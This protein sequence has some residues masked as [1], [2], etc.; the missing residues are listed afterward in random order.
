M[1]KYMIIASLCFL[2]IGSVILAMNTLEP[3]HCSLCEH[4]PTHAPCLVNLQTGEVGE[5]T[6][7]DPHPFKSDEL[8]DNQYGGYF[9][10]L[11][12]AGLT[13]YR[14][15]AR[16]E[17]HLSIPVGE[18]SYDDKFFC[19]ACRSLLKGCSNIGFAI[20]DIK[21]SGATIVY[22]IVGDTSFNFRCYEIDVEKRGKEDCE[23][24]VKGTLDIE[25]SY[26]HS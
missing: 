7:Y 14:D 5:L 8:A 20:A 21:V 22:T 26:T 16:W 12:V 3:D 4:P 11:S 1:K 18:Y 13:G 6:V 9:S 17:T 15:T 19:D 24:V 2:I 10:F 25:E 23:I